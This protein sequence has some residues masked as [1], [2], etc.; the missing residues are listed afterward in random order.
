MR[1]H[2]AFTALALMCAVASAAA[3]REGVAP[4][5]TQFPERARCG[6]NLI[7]VGKAIQ[8]YVF[9]RGG[10]FPS[11]LSEVFAVDTE[12]AGW[13]SL[14]CPAGEPKFTESALAPS[15]AYEN[16]SDRKAP[17]DKTDILVFDRAPVHEGGRNVLLADLE[18]VRYLTEADFQQQFA[19]QKARWE[20]QGRK[21]S[22][23]GEKNDDDYIPLSAEQIQ[24]YERSRR[25]FWQSP[26]LKIVAA[27]VV[28]MGLVSAL[29]IAHK[30]KHRS[31]A[32]AN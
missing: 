19:A 18:T 12:V 7:D 6:V 13:Q 9:A 24:A 20:K 17:D 28:A 27:L 10:N 4:S 11:R 3:P 22:I 15:Y 25:S 1:I 2:A 30:R 26:H 8:A 5:M 14:I 31:Q 32:S 29:L 23:V 16:L 21:F